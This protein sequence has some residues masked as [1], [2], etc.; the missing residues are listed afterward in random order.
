[1]KGIVRCRPQFRPDGKLLTVTNGNKIM[2]KEIP[3]VKEVRNDELKATYSKITDIILKYTEVKSFDN[4]YSL[5]AE[6]LSQMEISQKEM[7]DI[8]Q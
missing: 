2:I 8:N 1:M 5:A 7:Q 6:A 4:D 3:L